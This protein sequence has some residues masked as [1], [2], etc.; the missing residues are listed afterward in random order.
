MAIRPE[1]A[2]EAAKVPKMN[3]A[4]SLGKVMTLGQ[5]ALQPQVIQQQLDAARIAEQQAQVTLDQQ[6]RQDIARQRLAAITKNNVK[7]DPKTGK[8]SV[9]YRQIANI[10]ASEGLE[11]SIVMEHLSKAQTQEQQD[12]K[13]AADRRDYLERNR[14]TLDN[15]LRNETDPV[16]AEQMLQ[17]VIEQ[18][19]RLLKDSDALVGEYYSTHYPSNI[20][21][22]EQA[23]ANFKSTVQTVA[24][25]QALEISA[26]EAEQRAAKEYTSKEARDPNSQMSRTM[27]E[28]LI[29]Q[30]FDVPSNMSAFEINNN[31]IFKKQFEALVPGEAARIAAAEKLTGVEST[32]DIIK[33]GLDV[34]SRMQKQI[35]PTKYGTLITSK[36]N[37]VIKQVPEHGILKNAVAAHNQQ[38]PD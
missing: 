23:K 9:D 27:R 4:E 18:D 30:G 6:K 8:V 38:F 16:K 15:L 34:A 19:A 1:I 22:I 5:L 26:A 37:Q 31:P 28:Q 3:L 17:K 36:L 14:K 32:R 11:P 24:E 2:L 20:N 25:Q 33:G 21:P 29:A 35:G 7:T 13:T 10:A 12:I